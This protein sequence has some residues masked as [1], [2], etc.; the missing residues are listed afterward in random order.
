MSVAKGATGRVRALIANM[1]L[2]EKLGQLTMLADG[3]V[4]T[5][6]PGP[7]NPFTMIGEG[8]VGS[9]LNVWGGDLIREAQRRAVEESRLGVPLF[10]GLDVVHGHRSI[11]P[12]PLAEACAFDRDLWR[13]TARDS[14]IEASADGIHMTFSPMIDVSRDCRWGRIVESAGE[15]PY[16]TS[17]FARA[18][19]R[20]YQEAGEDGVM[21]LAACAKHF[22]AYGAV[23]AGRDYAEADVSPRALEEVHL[24]PF[25]AA[26]EAG[27]AAIMPAFIDVAGA[28]MTAHQRLLR[29]VLRAQ[30]RFDG[31]IVSDY[32]AIAELVNHGVAGDLAHASA[33]ALQAGVDIDM[34]SE[35]Y[36]RGLPEA[37]SRGL[38]TMD[39]IEEALARV[40][41]FKER[42]GLF[43]DPFRGMAAQA[44]VGLSGRRERAREA[45]VRSMALVKNAD[46]LLPLRCDARIALIGPMADAPDDQLGAWA[47]AGAG[48]Q[49]VSIVQGLREA[50]G[51]ERIVHAG[52]SRF[53]SADAEALAQ[54]RAA[55]LA[56]ET[57]VL[58]LGEE[59]FTTGEACSRTRP[60][61]PQAQ[62]D[63][64]R[65]IYGQG[66]PVALVLCTS[67]PLAL[68]D[69]LVDGA[70]AILVAWHAGTMMGPALADLLSGA[71]NP[72]GKLC[73]SWPHVVGQAP[74]FYGVR[75]SGRPHDP[76]NG[77]STRF[78]DAPF[79]PRWSFGAGFGYAR[80]RRANL[81][82]E[83]ACVGFDE[84]VEVSVDVTNEG[85]V[86]GDEIVFAFARDP[87]AEVTRPVLELKD[88]A[89]LS[90]APG[91]TVTARFSIPA[92]AFAYPGLDMKPRLDEGVI[93][94]HI[95]ASALAC[96][97][98][99]IDVEV[100]PVT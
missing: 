16:V 12:V 22:C 88:F 43:D 11:H 53:T 19:V 98:D 31:L 50:F 91:E 99:R 59:R 89:R 46:D 5:G 83:R 34:M 35:A 60:E 13:L 40:L 8:R 27:V 10:F 66:R 52:G 30:W 71:R 32:N 26:V 75:P 94:L 17:E 23:L 77:W 68:P 3:L 69:W 18:R 6:P 80:F 48:A 14:A 41:A 9:L 64:A 96:D 90:L 25:R 92:R 85:A 38:V 51:A 72:S 44:P 62:L 93:Q 79:A 15:D 36:V 37:L 100:L 63:L 4:E 21:R 65:E 81:R 61:L 33:L 7:Q 87:L 1:T 70:H 29:E 24:P 67:R 76:A 78:L 86:A 49:S 58:C 95:G 57:I 55:A 56:S 73:V 20:G 54:A 74:I 82:V 47:S 39:L 42:L 28:P 84:C 2:E 97:L 45:A